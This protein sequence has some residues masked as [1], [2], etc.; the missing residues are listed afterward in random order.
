MIFLSLAPLLLRVESEREI[1][2][3]EKDANGEAE[4]LVLTHT[5]TEQAHVHAQ[6]GTHLIAIRNMNIIE[7]SSGGDGTNNN[8][9]HWTQLA[10]QSS[11]EH[12]N[13]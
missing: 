4:Y 13:C 10:A 1:K 3:I 7:A 6:Y 8:K 5:Q 12:I 9:L 2:Q 11:T